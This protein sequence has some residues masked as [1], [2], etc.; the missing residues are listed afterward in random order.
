MEL[1]A[2]FLVIFLIGVQVG[3]LFASWAIFYA[4][5]KLI[6]V[7]M[8]G[9]DTNLVYCLPGESYDDDTIE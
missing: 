4:I 5:G 3:Q 2:V 1:L 7:L 9:Y 6:K 8:G